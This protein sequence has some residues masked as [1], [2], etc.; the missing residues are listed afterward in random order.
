M[1]TITAF[2]AK[3][4]LRRLATQESFEAP[5]PSTVHDALLA[6]G[7]IPDPFFRLNEKDLQWIEAEDWEYSFEL[8][9]G[10]LPAPGTASAVDLC[11]D[12]L[13]TY[14]EIRLNGELVG[15]TANMFHGHEFR[16][17]AGL[18]PGKNQ[19][20][21]RFRSPQKV[22][23]PKA[24]ALGY[25]LP[26][27]N[28]QSEVA[29][30]GDLKIAPFARKAP[31]QYGWDWGPRFVTSG[32]WRSGC[33]RHWQQARLASVHLVTLGL[34]EMS[35][36]DNGSPVTAWAAVEIHSRLEVLKDGQ[37]L[38][39]HC[40]DG[41]ELGRKTLFLRAGE[42][43]VSQEFRLA[44]PRLWW[45]NGMGSPE[46]YDLSSTLE[47]LDGPAASLLDRK[48]SRT[49][50]RTLRLVREKDQ[51]G[52]SFAF[53]INGLPVFAR[54]A[55]Y[56][57]NH[58][59]LPRVSPTV[60]HHILGSAH[61][62]HMNMLRVWGGGIYEDPL[63][64]QLCDQYG[65]MVWQDFMFACAMY[66]GDE[67]FLARVQTEAR[68]AVRA[69]RGHACLALWCG[70]NEI[71]SAWRWDKKGAGWQWKERLP[72][73]AAEA[74]N[75]A[76][77]RIFHHILPDTIRQEDPGRAYWPSSPLADW[78]KPA[79]R[80]STEGDMHYWG[81]WH[82]D[83]AF[84]Q[85]QKIMPRFMSEYGFQS[86]PEPASIRRFASLPQDAGFDS[87]VMQAHQRSPI[88]NQAIK[89][90]M[91]KYLKVPAGFDDF[92]LASQIL[93]AEAIRSA[94][95]AH[96]LNKPRCMGSLFWQ[97]NDCWPA[98]SWSSMDFYG[99]WKALHRHAR[100]VYRPVLL[101]LETQADGSIRVMADNDGPAD[102]SGKLVV[103]CASLDGSLQV[104]REWPAVLPR[105]GGFAG[106]GFRLEELAPG[107][108]GRE[109]AFL[110]RFDQDNGPVWENFAWLERTRNLDLPEPGFSL[111]LYAPGHSEAAAPQAGNPDRE[112]EVLSR[113]LSGYNLKEPEHTAILKLSSRH[114]ARFVHI[115]IDHDHP[116]AGEIWPEDDWFDLLPGDIR[117]IRIR[118]ALPLEELRRELRIRS[119]K[120]ICG[121]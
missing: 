103:L 41:Q 50:I 11:F 52:K 49:G 18:R 100:R 7:Q 5:I 10:T 16:N 65:I 19:V 97:L 64:Y 27:S 34:G 58:N 8:D 67:A 56:I 22:D 29:G 62:A 57:P 113:A 61:G 116:L 77:D 111:E 47:A 23:I 20:A 12:G 90:Y 80:D 6:A 24:R 28:E 119:A 92:I 1:L 96:R 42:H 15:E 79:E 81:V 55:N 9:A 17:P 84:E 66:P 83:E 44:D 63:F 105:S 78:Y 82:G 95:V 93:Q 38:L 86:F 40:L 74:L 108:S 45:C 3:G 102:L 118:S 94:I 120:D 2:P 33:L 70:N 30:L 117:Y 69:L 99:R 36:R 88:G 48:A 43:L 60:Y 85:Y 68:A 21:V 73:A 89:R 26:S 98:A 110:V 25:G 53:E 91:E 4:K 115:E 106:P 32:L 59:F 104:R 101:A 121:L 76:Y 75:Q 54:G 87:E 37:Y 51:W 71:D 72:Q 46:L 39:R 114:A 112:Q 31:Y 14:A 35:Q 13:D 107:K 109:L